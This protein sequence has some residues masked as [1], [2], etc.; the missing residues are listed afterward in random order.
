MD[1]WQNPV[2]A[3]AGHTARF[4]T[5]IPALAQPPAPSRLLLFLSPLSVRMSVCTVCLF[6]LPFRPCLRPSILP[7]IY[8]ATKQRASPVLLL[9]SHA[10]RRRP[11]HEDGSPLHARHDAPPSCLLPYGPLPTWHPLESRLRLEHRRRY[12]GPK[13]CR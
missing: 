5:P 1:E 9:L 12:V 10:T 3:P 13:S 2:E 11:S 6:C 7:R 8:R 4:V